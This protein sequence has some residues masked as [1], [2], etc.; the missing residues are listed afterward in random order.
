M[1]GVHPS[2]CCS[3]QLQCTCAWHLGELTGRFC[4]WMCV[5]LT[6]AQWTCVLRHPTCPQTE[7]TEPASQGALLCDIHNTLPARL[8]YVERFHCRVLQTCLPWCHL[9]DR[10]ANEFL[11][12]MGYARHSGCLKIRCSPPLVNDRFINKYPTRLQ[13]F[14]GVFARRVATHL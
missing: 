10:K 3:S 9:A 2:G 11:N 8:V 13:S 4:T 6:P 14:V 1:R 12:L 7:R 5:C